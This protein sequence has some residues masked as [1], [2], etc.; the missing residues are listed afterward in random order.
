MTT[1]SVTSAAASENENVQR[2][3]FITLEGIDG[4][5]KTTQVKLIADR[6]TKDGHLVYVTRFPNYDSDIGHLIKQYLSNKTELTPRVQHLLFCANRAEFVDKIDRLV[7]EGFIV[8]CD[9]YVHSGIAYSVANGLELEWCRS[10]E[11]A[12]PKPDLTIL[13]S[14]STYDALARKTTSAADR[15]DGKQDFLERVAHAYSQML[16][17]A[18]NQRYQNIDAA[19]AEPAITQTILANIENCWKYVHRELPL[20]TL[21]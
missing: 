18:S 12:L 9:R 16:S 15:Y 13:L 5:G 11:R 2:G 6:L 10:V 3:L 14:I 17:P 4:S 8:I 19:Q 1:S 20:E 21:F 7:N